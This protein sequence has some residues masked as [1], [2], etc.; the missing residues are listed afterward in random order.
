MAFFLGGELNGAPCC[1]RS[2]QSFVATSP[3]KRVLVVAHSAGGAWLCACLAET[4]PERLGRITRIALTDTFQDPR[5]LDPTRAELLR[6]RGRHWRTGSEPLGT[7]MADDERNGGCATYS[8]GTLDHAS[9]NY[10]AK[11]SIFRFFDEALAVV[12]G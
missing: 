11:D 4:P 10:C 6:T 5:T 12:D 8:A 9:T 1:V 3:A 2:W 7:P